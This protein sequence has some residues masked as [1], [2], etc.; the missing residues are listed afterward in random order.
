MNLTRVVSQEE[1]LAASRDLLAREKEFTRQRDALS[2]ARRALPMVKVEKE[3]TFDGPNGTVRLGDLFAGRGQLIV[4]HFM[5]APSWEA[6]CDGCSF[7]CDHVDAARQHFEHH[8]ISFTAISRAPLA[9][10]EAYK[11]RMGWTF[12]WVSSGDGDF[13]YDYQASFRREDLD[14]GPVLYN[15]TQQKLRGEDQPGLSVF[16]RGENGEIYHTYSSYERG[17][18]LLIGAYNFIDLT[19]IGRNET[20]GMENWMKRHDEYDRV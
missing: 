10:L 3:Y 2:A 5:F 8:D 13:N 9:R 17:L 14:R 4:Y 11:K 12:P 19:P 18:D 7:V 15:F 6:G 20:G 16:L 1:W